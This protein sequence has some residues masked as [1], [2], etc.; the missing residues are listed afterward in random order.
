MERLQREAGFKILLVHYRGTSPALIDLIAG[1]VSA[2]VSP[3]PNLIE[4]FRGGKVRPVAV[5]TKT[6]VS[7]LPDV[8]TLEE[9]GF[10]NFEIGSWYGLW[11]PANMPKDVVATLNGA[12]AEAMKTPRVTERVAKQGLIPVGSSSADFAAFQNA[13]IAKFSQMI[14]DANIKPSN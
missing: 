1:R 5:A 7:T 9:S 8:P 2:M 10:P 3:V 4:Q 6:R 14:K 11:G 13:E 12:I